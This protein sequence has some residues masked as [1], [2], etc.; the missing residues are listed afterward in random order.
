MS[1]FMS[2]N[3]NIPLQ[4]FEFDDLMTFLKTQRQGFDLSLSIWDFHKKCKPYLSYLKQYLD[5]KLFQIDDTVNKT[6]H[7][8][9][10]IYYESEI[11]SWYLPSNDNDISQQQRI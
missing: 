9:I 6:K 7:T 11:F 5:Q 8:R 10:V 4:P 2:F 1:L 3:E